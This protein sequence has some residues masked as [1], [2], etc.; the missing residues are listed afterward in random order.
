[1]SGLPGAA[2]VNA[3]TTDVVSACVGGGVAVR[4]MFQFVSFMYQNQDFLY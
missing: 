1:V 3:L 2:N 4:Q